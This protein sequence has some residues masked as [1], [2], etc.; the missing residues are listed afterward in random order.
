[1]Q[2]YANGIGQVEAKYNEI[3]H[4]VR[5]NLYSQRPNLYPINT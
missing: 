3:G 1:M 5:R 4:H 2:R